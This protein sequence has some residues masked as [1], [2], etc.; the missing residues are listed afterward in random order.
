MICTLT[1]SGLQTLRQVYTRSIEPARILATESLKLELALSDLV[2]K[3]YG[4]TPD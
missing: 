3:A 4:L 1:A 2:N